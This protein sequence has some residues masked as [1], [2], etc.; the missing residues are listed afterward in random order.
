MSRETLSADPDILRLAVALVAC[1]DARYERRG[2]RDTDD[3]YTKGATPRGRHGPLKYKTFAELVRTMPGAAQD[4]GARGVWRISKVDWHAARDRRSV[5]A[6]RVVTNEPSIA[7]LAEF[8]L[9]NI[10]AG[11]R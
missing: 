11:R 9:A 3:I 5:P 7:E 2:L 4:G 1:L 10:R 6:L 8:T